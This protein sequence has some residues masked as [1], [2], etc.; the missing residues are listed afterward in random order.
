MFETKKK[1]KYA[2]IR[3]FY[4][5]FHLKDRLDKIDS[6]LKRVDARESADIIYCI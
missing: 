3:N 4:I 1:I 5:N 6:L 2:N